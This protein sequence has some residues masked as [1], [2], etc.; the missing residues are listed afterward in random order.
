[1]KIAVATQDFKTVASH[2]GRARRF[3]VF[4]AE[5]GREPHLLKRWDFPPEMILHHFGGGGE[6]PVDEVRAV[7]TGASG[8]GFIN[9]MVRR[10]I[11]CVTTGETNPVR[12]V[13]DFLAGTVTPAEALA[14]PH[15]HHEHE[16][17]EPTDDSQGCHERGHGHGQ[18]RCGCS[19]S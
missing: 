14:H 13:K 6:H 15:E 8:Q 17:D 11:R 5:A 19:H 16:D 7:I 3:L 2:G 1:M 10:G 9:H 4:E 18:G 12:A